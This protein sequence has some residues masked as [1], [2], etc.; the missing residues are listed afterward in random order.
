MKFF[1][2]YPFWEAFEIQHRK[3]ANNKIAVRKEETFSLIKDRLF[4]NQKYLSRG[5]TDGE[6]SGEKKVNIVEK[7]QPE[8]QIIS[9]GNVA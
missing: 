3:F 2:F 7:I 8:S 1:L 6:V 5:N 4:K 9:F